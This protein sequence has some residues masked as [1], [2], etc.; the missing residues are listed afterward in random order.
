MPIHARKISE[1]A[2]YTLKGNIR[3]EV[4]SDE[5]ELVPSANIFT[6]EDSDFVILPEQSNKTGRK[7][8]KRFVFDFSEEESVVEPQC[9]SRTTTSPRKKVERVEDNIASHKS[10]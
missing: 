7:K 3:G 10:L 9:S 4:D 6:Y 1:K 8:R 5:R 2:P